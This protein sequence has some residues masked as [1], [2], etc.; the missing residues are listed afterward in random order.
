MY[1]VLSKNHGCKGLSKQL[2]HI[3][4]KYL[5]ILMTRGSEGLFESD[6]SGSIKDVGMFL[7]CFLEN[8]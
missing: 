1:S 2:S 4:T 3:H 5:H 7:G 6:F 8:M